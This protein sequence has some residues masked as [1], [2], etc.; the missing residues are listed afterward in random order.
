MLIP[1][2]SGWPG[3]PQRSRPEWPPSIDMEQ[4]SLILAFG[5][6]VDSCF[7]QYLARQFLK[8]R[9]ATRCSKKCSMIAP[10]DHGRES[11]N[12][13]GSRFKLKSRLADVHACT[14]SMR[15]RLAEKISLK[16]SPTVPAPAHTRWDRAEPSRADLAR[17]CILSTTTREHRG[18]TSGKCCFCE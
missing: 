9:C 5:R 10:I 14:G 11:R 13:L 16:R 12:I 8:L 3:F 17:S 18:D 6:W 2:V 4:G 1:K 7:R 15:W